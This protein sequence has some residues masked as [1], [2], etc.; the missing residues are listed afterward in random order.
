VAVGGSLL[1]DGATQVEALDDALGGELEVLANELDEARLGDGARAEGVDAD[2]DRLGYSDGVG[3]LDLD[4]VG[5]AGCD[6]V[7]GNV[8][9]HVGCAAVDLGGV[10]S[11]EG[12]SSVTAHAA[13]GVHD[14][15]TAGKAGV[16]H[17]SADDEAASGIDVVLRVGVEQV[18]WDDGLDDMLE[19]F[20]A[21][22]VVGEGTVGVLV[23]EFGVLGGDDDGVD[24][25]RLVVGVV[26]Y[27]DL[28]LAIGAKVGELSV[29][30]NLRE[31]LG[32][33][34]GERDGRGHQLG[35]LV[36]GVA[37]HHSLVAGSAGV[38]TLRDVG[39][40][41]VNGGDDGAG[42]GVEAFE[43]VVVPDLVDRVAD[44]GLEV[45]VG[46]GSDLPGD[47][48]QAGAGEG[49]AGNAAVGVDG[50]AGVE[51]GVGDLVGDLVR[52]TFG[53]GLTGEEE[54]IGVGRQSGKLLRSDSRTR[55]GENRAPDDRPLVLRMATGVAAALVSGRSGRCDV[56]RVNRTLLFYLHLPWQG[57]RR[58]SERRETRGEAGGKGDE[59]VYAF[60]EIPAWL[61]KR[62]VLF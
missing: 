9:G 53:H 29:L 18:G 41:A 15:L 36:G 19:D 10:L 40:L 14:D 43:G 50:Q 33:L 27:R 42:V 56:N 37:E 8:A 28:R 4:A 23:G 3:E 30:A 46:L 52:V 58:I 26:L 38:D 24:A 59:R 32:Q 12:T 39:R 5:E 35:R 11:G 1:E 44:Q 22:L 51:D 25:D 55:S 16:S 62:I 47:D 20:G 48:D 17:G 61:Y 2:A 54:T 45:D 21:E 7:L 31:L 60:T 34:V 57:R 6:D 49:L 13:V